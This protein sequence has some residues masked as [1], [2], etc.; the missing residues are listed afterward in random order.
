M[1]AVGRILLAETSEHS[2]QDHRPNRF[3][4]KFDFGELLGRGGCGSVY[5]ASRVKPGATEVEVSA[6][7][8]GH[9]H[10][11]AHERGILRELPQHPHIVAFFDVHF[12]G[13]LGALALER[14]TSSLSEWLEANKPQFRFEGHRV[15]WQVCFAVDYMHGRQLVH[16]DIKAANALVF[17]DVTSVPLVKLSDFSHS[18]SVSAGPSEVCKGT[19]SIRCPQ[20]LLREPLA[21]GGMPSDMW[22]VGCLTARVAAGREPFRWASST[23]KPMHEC[24]VTT[25]LKIFHTLGAPSESTWPGYSCLQ[26]RLGDEPSFD[27]SQSHHLRT[28]VEALFGDCGWPFVLACWTYDPLRRLRAH[29]ALAHGML[30]PWGVSITHLP[31]SQYSFSQTAATSACAAIIADTANEFVRVAVYSLNIQKIVCGVFSKVL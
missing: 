11:I 16:G 3:A 29:E 8:I 27:G 18:R 26:R 22:A 30:T 5:A 4:S 9:R 20:S 2:V 24:E 10:D 15:V 31:F 25:I 23:V 19:L 17:E 28:K 13:A 21:G 7:K 12:D 6:V 1:D 14:A